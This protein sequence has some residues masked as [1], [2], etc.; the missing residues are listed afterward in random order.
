MNLPVVVNDG[1]KAYGQVKA[2][3]G[4]SFEVKPGEL[5]GFIGPDGAGKT[6]LFRILTTLLIPGKNDSPGE[7]KK[8]AEFIA[9]I[10]KNIRYQIDAYF[11]AGE[12]PWRR[13]SVGE[14]EAAAACAGRYL[15]H[16]YFYKGTETCEFLVK[17]IFPSE[18]QLADVEPAQS[19]DGRELVVV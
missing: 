5:F 1:H 14:V 19:T 2:L 17:S 3:S 6:T 12:N 16:V 4:L 13:P 18:V 8:M 10:D 11:K 9:G 7:I 15:S